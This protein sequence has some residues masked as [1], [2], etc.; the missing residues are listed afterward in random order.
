MSDP[1]PFEDQVLDTL[2]DIDKL[3]RAD[4][5][6]IIKLGVQ[7]E[8]SQKDIDVLF[9]KK[10]DKGDS[11]NKADTAAAVVVADRKDLRGFWKAVIVQS[12]I[13]IGTV[14]AAWAALPKH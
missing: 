3:Q 1:R 7:L 4:H 13:T 14:L 12:I 9:R 8:R 6:L 5:D 2:R 11:N 10:A